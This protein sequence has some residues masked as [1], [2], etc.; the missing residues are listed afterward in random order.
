MV[1]KMPRLIDADKIKLPQGFFEKVD[2]VPKFYEW[3]DEQPTVD[4]VPLEDYK[5]ME[6]TVYKLTKAIAD[7]SPVRCK[8]CI[9]R[10]QWKNRVLYPPGYWGEDEAD[11]DWT[12]PLIDRNELRNSR[13][14]DD[15]FY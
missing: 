6:R 2:N 14:M 15:D 12:C 10:P 5:S 7:A 9:H 1:K 13:N 8:D 11:I 4:A 3:L